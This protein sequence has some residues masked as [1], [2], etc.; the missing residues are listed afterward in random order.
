MSPAER[1]AV[2]ARPIDSA[3]ELHRASVA[4]PPLV[5]TARCPHAFQFVLASQPPHSSTGE[6]RHAVGR[7]P[8][9]RTTPGALVIGGFDVD[10]PEHH[11]LPGWGIEEVRQ[12]AA[13]DEESTGVGE[14][15]DFHPVL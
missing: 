1:S 12:H 5:R 10:E 14:R 15:D 6:V 11:E 2:I 7:Q 3:G 4:I 13:E 9:R 8:R